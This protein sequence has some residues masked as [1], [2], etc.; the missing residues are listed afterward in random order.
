MKNENIKEVFKTKSIKEIM[1]FINEN[2]LDFTDVNIM[3]LKLHKHNNNLID[4]LVKRGFNVN[5]QN[6]HGYTVLINAIIV[7]NIEQVKYLIQIGA[8]VNITDTHNFSPLMYALS[9]N[10]AIL[11]EQHNKENVKIIEKVTIQ[12]S[13][14]NV[15]KKHNQIAKF[16]I[17]NGADVHTKSTNDQTAYLIALKADNTEMMNILVQNGV[18]IVNTHAEYLNN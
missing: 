15:P 6:E 4:L 7:G 18:N 8:D 10:E 2:N 17:V 16:L 13:L 12:S 5:K 14:Q 9:I 1:T 3:D 11:L